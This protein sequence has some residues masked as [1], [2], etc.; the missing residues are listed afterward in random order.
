[1]ALV[2]LGLSIMCWR[3]MGSDWRMAV[4]PQGSGRLIQSGPFAKVRHPIYAVSIVLM[5]CSVVAVPNLPMMVV[6]GVHIMLMHIKARHE[7][8]FLLERHGPAYADYCRRTGRFVPRLF[9][10]PAGET[11]SLCGRAK[12]GEGASPDS[13]ERRRP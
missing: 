7:E 5:I 2:C 12:N 13:S 10:R 4:D 3:H 11:D 1:M 9:G 6:A 8:R